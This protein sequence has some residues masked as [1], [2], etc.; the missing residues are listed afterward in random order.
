M[1]LGR[2]NRNSIFQK[3]PSILNTI[4][5]FYFK[6]YIDSHI[7]CVDKTTECKFID[8][9]SESIEKVIELLH[10]NNQNKRIHDLLKFLIQFS[11]ICTNINLNQNQIFKINNYFSL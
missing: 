9:L 3:S 2:D 8:F 11:N 5:N 6:L 1:R 10:S 7:Q 4:S